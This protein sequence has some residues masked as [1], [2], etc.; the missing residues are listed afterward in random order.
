MLESYFRND[1]QVDSEWIYEAQPC[2][3]E[4]REKFP[5]IAVIESNFLNILSYIIMIIMIY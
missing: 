4:F 2:F 3:R 5:D 1:Q